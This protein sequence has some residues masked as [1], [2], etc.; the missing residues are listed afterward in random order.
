MDDSVKYQSMKP[1]A[2]IGAKQPSQ[3]CQAHTAETNSPAVACKPAELVGGSPGIPAADG[4]FKTSDLI[5]DPVGIGKGVLV[6]ALHRNPFT[7]PGDGLAAL[8]AD[9][10]F[11][12]LGGSLCGLLLSGCDFAFLI[13]FVGRNAKTM[14]TAD[15]C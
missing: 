14:N 7:R 4:I 10:I 3:V 15:R 2:G 12:F 6:G 9:D 11:L 5:D 13:R 1:I 8:A